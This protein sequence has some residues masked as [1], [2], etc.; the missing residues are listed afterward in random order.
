MQYPALWWTPLCRQ[1][2]AGWER[3]ALVCFLF[4]WL[5]AMA[6]SNLGRKR[7][8]EPYSFQS[9]MRGSQGRNSRQKPGG[10]NWQGGQGELLLVVP[11][12]TESPKNSQGG[13]AKT[14]A[15]QEFWKLGPALSGVLETWPSG[16]PVSSDCPPYLPS[17]GVLFFPPYTYN[18]LHIR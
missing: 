2:W 12:I 3:D 11:H 17:P 8:I 18:D 13:S 9:I 4:L 6:N 7:F 1:R 10:R 15:G 14:S 5:K 16:F